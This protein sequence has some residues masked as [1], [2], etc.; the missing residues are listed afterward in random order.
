MG[1]LV[2]N[3]TPNIS[4]FSLFCKKKTYLSRLP[5]N[6]EQNYFYNYCISKNQKKEYFKIFKKSYYFDRNKIGQLLSNKENTEFYISKIGEQSNLPFGVFSFFEKLTNA[7]NLKERWKWLV[8]QDNLIWGDLELS[9]DNLNVIYRALGKSDEDS[10]AIKGHYEILNANSINYFEIKIL[11]TGR[12]GFIGIGLTHTDCDLDR[13]PGWEKFSIGYHGDD[14]HLF[15]CSG[16]GTKYGPTFSKGDIIGVCW[17]LIENTVFFTKNGKGLSLAFGNFSWFN[18][19]LMVPVIGLRSER[20]SV[21]ANFGK[22]FFEFN[23]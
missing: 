11:N 5:N 9:V 10:A 15:D 21:L 23:I 8:E 14:G 19:P 13:L 7:W 16:T 17:N 1:S 20:E 3:R 6:K 2:Y 12:E 18:L 22:K 4:K